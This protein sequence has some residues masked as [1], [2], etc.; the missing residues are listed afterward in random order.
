M[1]GFINIVDSTITDSIWKPSS[2][3]AVNQT[4]KEW[5]TPLKRIIL[6]I[7]QNKFKPVNFFVKI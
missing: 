6:L 5:K 2:D 4:P 1:M 3:F 7:V